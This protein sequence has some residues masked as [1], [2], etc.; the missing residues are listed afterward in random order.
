MILNPLRPLR[1]YQSAAANGIEEEWTSGRRATLLVLATGL[2]KTRVAAEVALRRRSLGRVLWIAHREELL[3]QAATA[4]RAD[5]GLTTDLERAESHAQVHSLFGGSDVVVASVPTLHAR[6]LARWPRNTFS[7]IVIDEAHHATASGYR[8]ILDHFEGAKVLGLT[9]T[10][11]RTDGVAL[12]GIFESCAFRYGIAEGVRDGFLS[13]IRA[14]KITVGDLD[15]S[16][17]RMGTD[18]LNSAD[19]EREMK[20]DGVL[21]QIASPLAQEAGDRQTIV[22]LPTVALAEELARVLSGY[23]SAERVVC[24]SASTPRERRRDILDA[25]RAG[26]V[27]FITNV[28]VLT[29]GFD[30][31]ATSCIAMARPTKS[32]SL[33]TQC[34]GRGTRLSPGKEY[35]L[36]LDFCASNAD[37]DLVG[38]ADVLAG[39]DMPEAAKD[40][41][42]R[43][44]TSGA[45]AEELDDLIA[46][47]KEVADRIEQEAAKERAKARLRLVVPY[48]RRDMELF[49][50]YAGLVDT[51]AKTLRDGPDHATERQRKFLADYGI[52]APEASSKSSASDMI[53]YLSKRNMPTIKQ[54]RSLARAGLR[55]DVSRGE[56][57]QILDALQA[58]R[59]SATDEMRARWGP[60]DQ[61]AGG[62]I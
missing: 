14:K 50:Q 49:P 34:V 55:T 58:N 24:I 22:F 12:G 23:V 46:E 10:P 20:S 16:L 39:R 35:C 43:R 37:P 47:A 19:L 25:Y 2:G 53:T 62:T 1:P 13:P 3:E 51:A 42:E 28:G 45:A 44:L 8:G 6:R 15:L 18:D 56:A 48:A 11:D 59:W 21:H 26:A 61:A 38:P 60:P 17:V 41:I 27:Q 4:L 29:E 36:L 57:S 52:A 54:A 7:T 32:R 33:Y 31:P 9:A 30:A 5:G 40:L